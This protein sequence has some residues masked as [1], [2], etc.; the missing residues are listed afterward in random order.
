ML[1]LLLSRRAPQELLIPL[2][3]IRSLPVRSLDW[4]GLDVDPGPDCCGD[5]KDEDE[6]VD[7]DVA[8]RIGFLSELPVRVRF[9]AHLKFEAM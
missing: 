7:V 2:S 3:V 1:P 6:D 4:T 8:A 5:E 9:F